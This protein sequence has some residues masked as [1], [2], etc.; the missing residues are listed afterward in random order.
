MHN[1]TL[2]FSM[3]CTICYQL[4]LSTFVPK[5]RAMKE[6]VAHQGGGGGGGHRSSS[7]SSASSSSGRQPSGGPSVSGN[8]SPGLRTHLHQPPSKS[9]SAA[10]SKKP[11]GPSGVGFYY[12]SCQ[13]RHSLVNGKLRN[14]LER[15]DS[16]LITISFTSVSPSVKRVL[17][18]RINGDQ[19]RVP[20]RRIRHS[21]KSA[22]SM[23]SE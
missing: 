2:L 18:R 7:N 8:G 17:Q 5:R 4:S 6:G 9:P 11:K 13:N 23:P 14:P 10:A 20:C 19:R 1:C 16:L 21:T 22:S 15:K 3:K 12:F